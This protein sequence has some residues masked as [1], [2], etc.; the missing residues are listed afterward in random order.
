MINRRDVLA[1][2]A[3]TGAAALWPAGAGA[4]TGISTDKIMFGQ[5]AALE[6]PAAALGTG[7]RDGILAAFA[8]INAA[9]GIGNRKLELVSNDDGYE[10]AKSIEA[11]KA[12]IGKGV[13]A[14]IGPVGTPTSMA[15][16][17]IVKQAGIPFIGAFT[18]TEAL[19]NPYQPLAVNIRASYF[20]ETEMMVDR[21]VKDRGASKIAILYQDDAFGQAGLAG[22]RRAI[23]KRG[24]SLVA[25]AA[26]ERNTVAVKTALLEIRKTAPQAVIMIGPYKPCAEFI[27]VSRSINFDPVFINIS[28]VGSNALAQ[29]LGPAGAGVLVTQVV[30]FPDDT[31]IPVVAAFHKALKAALPKA[32][33]G[34][35]SLEGYLV[36][37]TVIAGLQKVGGEPTR[38]ALMERLTNGSYDL[39]GFTLNYTPK[40]NQGSNAVFMTSI[41]ADGQFKPIASIV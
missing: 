31:T 11:T 17:P 37:R 1:G 39:G 8:E 25:E 2:A 7:M 5:A 35:V 10:P 12:L 21:L 29:E 4:E 22:T 18:G 13:F 28:F 14:L 32:E 41:G 30:P 24:M 36:G 19:R 16:F 34:F 38:A 33:P 23:G 3:V 15:A 20:Q 6:G 40:S 27:K 26:F 9:G